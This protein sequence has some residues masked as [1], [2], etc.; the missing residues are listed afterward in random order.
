M[1]L[2]LKIFIQSGF[3]VEAESKVTQKQKHRNTI[4]L[5]KGAKD[6]LKENGW[7]W[8]NGPCFAVT[9]AVEWKC[10]FP[11]FNWNRLTRRTRPP[12][13]FLAFIFINNCRIMNLK[14]DR[15]S[16]GSQAAL[17]YPVVNHIRLFAIC[18]GFYSFVSRRRRRQRLCSVYM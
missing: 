17:H 7:S 2:L 8:M 12:L 14:L 9:V 11:H 15:F 6:L 10:C 3:G 4:I 18:G 13:Y 16:F 5:K 1:S